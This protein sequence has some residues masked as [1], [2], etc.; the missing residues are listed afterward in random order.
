MVQNVNPYEVY[1]GPQ[2]PDSPG[3][4]VFGPQGWSW[5]EPR[6]KTI[7][8][9]LDGTAKV[10]DQHGRAIRGVVGLD[11]KPIMFAPG[12]PANDDTP[13]SRKQYANHQQVIAALEAER[14]D[15]KT[16]VSAGWPQIPYAELKKLKALPPTPLKELK[17][18]QDTQLR[19][20]ALRARREA[21]EARQKEMQAVDDE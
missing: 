17:K 14:C 3:G 18:I 5:G 2:S 20:D 16:L 12:P 9:F 11:N 4:F 21:D 15:W 7:T 13:D 10:S 1:T 19:K 8:F 6:P